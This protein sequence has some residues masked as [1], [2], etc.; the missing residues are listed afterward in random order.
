MST[1]EAAA[2]IRNALKSRYGWTSRQ[3]SVRSDLYSMGSTIRVLVKAPVVDI[4]KVR[5]IA[6][7]YARVSYDHASGEMLSGANRFVDIEWS[8]AV[9]ESI[10]T[11]L[12]ES[13]P[14]DGSV[15]EP[16]PG[17]R[18][19]RTGS[20]HESYFVAFKD[21]AELVHCWGREFC[22]RQLAIMVLEGKL[23]LTPS[24]PPVVEDPQAWIVSADFL[25]VA[26]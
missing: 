10:S 22:A 9:V 8:R 19:N 3:V 15:G 5:E 26:A 12:L 25:G 18:V 14:D 23:A 24:T 20:K 6:E 1:T 7:R 11:G 16:I 13:I 21:G 17:V 4:A 2:E